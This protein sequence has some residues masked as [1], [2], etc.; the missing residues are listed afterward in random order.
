M[1]LNKWIGLIVTLVVLGCSSDSSNND[2]DE[3]P[4]GGDNDFN[5][6]SILTNW[7]D[8]FIMPNYTAYVSA[9]S[10]LTKAANDFVVE[11]NIQSLTDLKVAYKEAYLSWQHVSM[12]EIG[13]AERIQLRNF[14]N[15]YPT[16]KANIDAKTGGLESYNLELPSSFSEQGFPALDYLLY[17]TGET[18]E[19]VLAYFEDQVAAKDYLLALVNRLDKLGSQV[20][21]NWKTGYRDTYVNNDSDAVNASFNKTVNAYVSYYERFLRSGK[22]GIPAGAL[23][24]QQ[25]PDRVEAYY[26]NDMSKE[27]FLKALDASK[28][29]YLG[30]G[31]TNISGA[32]LYDALK[33]LD[34]NELA[35]DIS[36]QFDVIR[37]EASKLNDSFSYEVE[38]NNNA[39]IGLRDLLQVNTILFKND[40]V[41]ALNVTISYQDND[42]D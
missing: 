10:K 38:N 20:L 1:K 21:E 16:N 23:S 14:T 7:A 3:N 32:S 31:A 22:V 12:F 42:G 13:E 4:T 41:S 33:G 37:E 11:T 2:G 24:G 5:R 34:Q 19:M 35:D 17:G 36:E 27:L 26:V 30:T 25:F 18:D 6:K 40:M 28:G 8:N 39:L 29:F 15:I 9:T